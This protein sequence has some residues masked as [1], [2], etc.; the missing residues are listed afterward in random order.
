MTRKRPPSDPPAPPWKPP[1]RKPTPPPNDQDP[2]VAGFVQAMKEAMPEVDPHAPT[3]ASM[4][5]QK[6]PPPAP[7]PTVAMPAVQQQ[8][9]I[10]ESTPRP[11]VLIVDDDRDICETLGAVLTEDAEPPFDVE[12][13]HDG[14]E[15][16]EAMH[17][18]RS[19][20]RKPA[21][22]LLDLTMPEYPGWS[23]IGFAERC[24][25]I[26]VP[27]RL[28][29]AASW[30]DSN[31]LDQRWVFLERYRRGGYEIIK[32]PFRGPTQIIDEVRKA[33]GE[34]MSRLPPY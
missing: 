24:W 33:M 15:A 8:G 18:L 34:R 10:Q 20:G 12:F 29:S 23:Y 31:K 13:A 27:F 28:I 2:E 4:A 6:P 14:R 22:V 5:A 16:V 3:Q 26:E 9:L 1:A 7:K 19:E 17:R 21:C 32:K 30:E 11:L 25:M